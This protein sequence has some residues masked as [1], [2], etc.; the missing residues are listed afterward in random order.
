V[1]LP[2]APLPQ[3][4]V[5]W[6]SVIVFYV[7]ACAVSWPFFWW[8]DIHW[9]S[10]QAWR[11]PTFLK[12]MTYMWG[13]GC[14]AALCLFLFR[15]THVR[16]ITVWGTSFRRSLAFYVV[17]LLLLCIP[18]VRQGESTS[19]VM[20]LLLMPIAFFTIFGEEF[21]WRGFLQD[22]VRPLRPLAR[23]SL[24]GVLWSF[25]HFTNGMTHSTE[26]AVR[27]VLIF[28]PACVLFSW[29]IGEATER[30]RSVIVAHT[31]HAWINL[32]VEFYSPGALIVFGVSILYWGWML[33]TWPRPE[34]AAL[35]PSA[36]LEPLH[37]QPASTPASREH[38]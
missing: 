36:Q 12:T 34:Q 9:E 21:G 2:S 10:F 1:N 16:R 35:A 31:F 18:G 25:W 28:Y 13:P 32:V 11:L 5:H 7:L 30:S 3:P 37:P 27:R 24:I 14:A 38:L 33:W 4:R 19:H 29:L 6:R 26:Q 8:R 23:Y 15:D 17:P 20:P 22:A